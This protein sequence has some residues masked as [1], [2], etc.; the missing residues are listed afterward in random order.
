MPFTRER[1][2]EY[3]A[4]LTR[5]REETTKRVGMFT[6]GA[7]HVHRNGQEVTAELVA[8]MRGEV[9]QL[10]WLIEQI[11]RELDAEAL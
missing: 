10:D 6:T 3:L 9:A 7:C 1:M 8:A 4:A 5:L 2:S 11:S